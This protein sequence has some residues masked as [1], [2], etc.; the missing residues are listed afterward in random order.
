MPSSCK[1]ISPPHL[2][3]GETRIAQ[4]SNRMSSRADNAVL[5]S[6]EGL[7][8]RA[9]PM[10]PVYPSSAFPPDGKTRNQAAAMFA[11]RT[12]E[13]RQRPV[14]Q[15]GVSP[16]SSFY[17]GEAIVDEEYSPQL[18]NRK[19]RVRKNGSSEQPFNAQRRSSQ[20]APE[21]AKTHRSLLMAVSQSGFKRGRAGNHT[22]TGER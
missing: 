2:N 16:K 12:Y 21:E 3:I 22:P 10:Q 15:R 7:S 5:R 17:K 6:V 20:R 11:S 14:S 18:R 19:P 13:D 8:D 1:F 9:R 4:M